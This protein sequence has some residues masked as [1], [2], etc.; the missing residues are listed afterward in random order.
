MALSLSVADYAAPVWKNSVH[1]KHIDVAVNESAHIISECLRPTLSEKIYPLLGIAPP[2]IRRQVAAEVER[3]NQMADNRHPYIDTNNSLGG[4]TQEG[5]SFGHQCQLTSQSKRGCLSYG[6]RQHLTLPWPW[7]NNLQ[8]EVTNTLQPGRLSIGRELVSQIASSTPPDGA[9]ST[10]SLCATVGM[11]RRTTSY[12]RAQ[13]SAH[14]VPS[15]I[16]S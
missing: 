1:V 6:R 10:G 12:W 7:K 16:Y 14:A 4:F 11:S 3:K 13:T 8:L 2:S 9:S 15:W 5:A